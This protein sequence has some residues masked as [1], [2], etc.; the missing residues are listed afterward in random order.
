MS[1]IHV[2]I[3]VDDVDSLKSIKDR[4]GNGFMEFIDDVA[5]EPDGAQS[6]T[7]II[8]DAEVDIREF[9]DLLHA[10]PIVD[11]VE[12]HEAEMSDEIL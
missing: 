12:V 2:H 11:T 3:T 1:Q 4:A 9:E 5:G 7:F 6:V 10:S 8:D